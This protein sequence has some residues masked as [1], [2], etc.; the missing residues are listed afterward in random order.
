MKTVI[1]KIECL[2]NLHVGSGDVN[3]NIIDNE[4]EKDAVTG[5]PMIHASGVK[6][7]LREAMKNTPGVDIDKIFG[8]AGAGNGGRPGTHKFFDAHIIS[9]PMRVFGSKKMSFIS[10]FTVTSINQY[11]KMLSAFGLNDYGFDTIEIPDFGNVSFLTNTTEDILIEGEKTSKIL[12]KLLSKL[13][14][15]KDVL[16]DSFAMADNFDDYAL[17]VV[18]RNHL[19]NGVSKNLWY[20]E[21]VPH[22][23]VMYFAVICNNEAEAIAIPEITQFGGNASIGCGF[24]KVSVLKED[25]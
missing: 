4:V 3:Y 24:C 1:Y 19:E 8:S 16:G 2:T 17:P 12:D 11:L 20:E 18:A 15:L 25:N 21:I 22:G 10:V 5:Y 14:K 9:R 13:N 23:T 6:G 7:A